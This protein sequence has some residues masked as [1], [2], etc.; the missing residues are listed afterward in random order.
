M[1]LCPRQETS[2]IGWCLIHETMQLRCHSLQKTV[3]MLHCLLQKTV[4]MHRH[5]LQAQCKCAFVCSTNFAWPQEL[6]RFPLPPPTDNLS[7]NFP[8]NRPGRW[9][10]S[11]PLLSVGGFPVCS[12][13]SVRPSILHA[14]LL[15]EWRWKVVGGAGMPARVLAEAVVNFLMELVEFVLESS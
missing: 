4:Q 15:L 10:S 1:R 13:P 2:Q 12:V 11:T 6:F 3:Q 9:S 8:K 5:L 14:L 7:R